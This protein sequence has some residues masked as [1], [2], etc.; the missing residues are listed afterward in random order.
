MQSSEFFAYFE[1][2]AL[3]K[4]NFKGIH[5][6]DQIPKFLRYRNFIICN[7]AKSSEVGEH[8]F[9]IFKSQR[10]AL[11]LFDSLG[12]SD[13]KETLIKEQIH[14]KSKYLSFNETQ[15][16]SDRSISCGKF[17][18]YFIIHRLYNLDLNFDEFLEEF[19]DSDVEINEMKVEKFCE[20][21]LKKTLLK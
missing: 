20:E 14:I 16:Q 1:D 9:V 11:E 13:E 18:I 21:I 17:C 8:W 12:V 7:T 2:F 15:F 3:G 6:F 10:N 4:R 19:F 5:S